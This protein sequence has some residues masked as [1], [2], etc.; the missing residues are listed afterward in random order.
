MDLPARQI[1]FSS[2]ISKDQKSEVNRI[3]NFTRAIGLIFGLLLNGYFMSE[4]TDSNVFSYG[5]LIAGSVKIVYDIVISF[6][7][8]SSKKG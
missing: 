7:F 4:T 5:F 8:L 3:I 2:I 6:L 1:Y